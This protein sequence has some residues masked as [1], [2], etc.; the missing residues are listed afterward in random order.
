MRV[1]GTIVSDLVKLGKTALKMFDEYVAEKN[2]QPPMRVYIRHYITD[3]EIS[4]TSCRS[5]GSSEII[6]KPDWT[7]IM[8]D[9]MEEKIKTLPEFK[10]LVQ[11]I[12]KK[13]K[14]NINELA[15]DCT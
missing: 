8:F 4:E 11:F 14:K 15:K 9:F 5:R 2:I 7:R 3:L 6:H 13:Y 1:V 10:Q 12:A